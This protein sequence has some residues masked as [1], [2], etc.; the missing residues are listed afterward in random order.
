MAGLKWS[1]RGTTYT[2]DGAIITKVAAFAWQLRIAYPDGRIE[3]IEKPTP[4]ACKRAAVRL[5]REERMRG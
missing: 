4:E 5:L 3:Y 2:A 1:K